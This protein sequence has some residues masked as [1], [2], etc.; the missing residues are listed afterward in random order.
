MRGMSGTRRG[1]R[2]EDVERGPDRGVA[3]ARGSGSRCRRPPRAATSSRSSS[4][5]VIQTPR[6]RSGGERPVGL[7]LDVVEQRRRPRPERAIGEALLPA[8]PGP[9]VAGRRRGRAAAEPALDRGRRGRRRAA[10]RGPGPAAARARTGGRRPGTTSR[11][12]GPGRA[13]PGSWHGDDAERE[14]LAARP[15]RSPPSSSSARDRRDVTRDEPGGGLVQ[16]ALGRAVGVAPDD[17][18]GRVGRRRVEPGRS[19]ARRGWPAGRGGRAPRTRHRRPGRDAS[20]GRRRSASGPSDRSPSRGPRAR[21]PDRPPPRAPRRS[22]PGPR[23]ASRRRSGRPGGSRRPRLGEMQVRVGQARDRDLVGLERDPLGERVGARLE[24][25]PRSRRTRSARRGCR[26][27]RPSRSRASPARVAIRPVMSMSSGMGQACRVGA[28]ARRGR[29]GRGRRPSPSASATRALTAH[30]CP[31]GSARPGPRSLRRRGTRRPAPARPA[32]QRDARA[33]GIPASI[34]RS[35]AASSDGSRV[36]RAGR[37]DDDPVAHRPRPPRRAATPSIATVAV[38]RWTR[39][40]ARA[41]ATWRRGP[42]VA[43]RATTPSAVDPPERAAVRAPERVERRRVRLGDVVGRLDRAGE[44]DDHARR[45][46]SRRRRRPAPRR[47]G[48]PAR[49]SPASSDARIAP[50]TTTGFGPSSTRSQQKRGLLDRVGALDD[51][52]AV[53]RRIRQRRAHDAGDLEQRRGT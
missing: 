39:S 7:G 53:D 34:A 1:R 51:D 52:R 6:R 9:A 19:R 17:A 42:R 30:R 49:R 25:R 46:A 43:G 14:Q 27:P 20:R 28:A 47:G 5:S 29:R 41:V 35:A 45:R 33:T 50:V 3:D 48:W 40:A 13:P 4:G 23:R 12:P 36:A 8:D 44:A 22:G 24:R 16:D 38:M 26:S 10:R 37:R 32:G 18:A 11:G 2:R 31:T 15:R 21:R